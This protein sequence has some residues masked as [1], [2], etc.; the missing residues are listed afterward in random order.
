MTW[1]R[2][3]TD[4]PT[5]LPVVL[6]EDGHVLILRPGDAG[7]EEAVADLA[8]SDGEADEE[9][10]AVARQIWGPKTDRD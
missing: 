7:Y 4:V 9:L 6:I 8:G 1:A 10:S 5:V 2:Q 3:V